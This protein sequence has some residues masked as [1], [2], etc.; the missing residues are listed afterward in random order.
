MVEYQ[1]KGCVQMVWK[2]A[3]KTKKLKPGKTK[4]V[5]LGI[6]TLMVGQFEDEYFATEGLCR[7]MRWPLAWGGKI[8]DGCIRCPL[9][10]TTHHIDDGSLEEWSPFPIFPAYGKILGKLSKPKDL[11]VYQTRVEG[12]FIQVQLDQS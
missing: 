3:I 10:Q 2:N 8:K 11:K 6:K 7:H 5:T 4:M 1:I 9:H 12:D